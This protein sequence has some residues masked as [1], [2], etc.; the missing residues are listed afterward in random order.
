[1]A[2]SK[3]ATPP[4][5]ARGSGGSRSATSAP[6]RTAGASAQPLRPPMR[7]RL[8]DLAVQAD[9][10]TMD[11]RDEIREQ[12]EVAENAWLAARARLRAAV[13]DA[14][15]AMAELKQAFGKVLADVAGAPAAA[16][17]VVRRSRSRH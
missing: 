13:A 11:M 14:D 7:G 8:E 16:E 3:R 6:K 15:Q 10:A 4:R 1:M 5:V 9:L 17:E 12:L 2:E